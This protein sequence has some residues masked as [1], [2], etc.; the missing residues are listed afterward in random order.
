MNI[1]FVLL[2]PAEKLL[3]I[4]I[5]VILLRMI[6]YA[7]HKCVWRRLIVVLSPAQRQ[8]LNLLL[9]QPA[10]TT[11]Q[12]LACFS[13]RDLAAQVVCSLA[14]ILFLQALALLLHQR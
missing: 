2:I 10:I 11:P 4:L 6:H 3:E 7:E 9:F 8:C 1:G 12:L 13:I 14:G 5:R